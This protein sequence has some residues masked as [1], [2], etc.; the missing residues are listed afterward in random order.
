MLYAAGLISPSGR[1]VK[2]AIWGHKSSP[3]VRLKPKSRLLPYSDKNIAVHWAL[4]PPTPATGLSAAEA[5]NHDVN[6]AV[7]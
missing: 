7:V 4:Q 5:M 2:R 6:G 1:G 3:S